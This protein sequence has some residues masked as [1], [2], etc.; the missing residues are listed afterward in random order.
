LP[1]ISADAHPKY[2]FDRYPGSLT[3]REGGSTIS[4]LRRP[5]FLLLIGIVFLAGCRASQSSATATANVNPTS[6]LNSLPPNLACGLSEL[7]Y[8]RARFQIDGTAADPVTALADDGTILQTYWSPGFSLGLATDA[9]ASWL[10]RDPSGQVVVGQGE[11][12]DIPAGAPPRLHG[13]RV[14]ATAH[15]MYILLKDPA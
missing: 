5:V 6:E 9:T 4:L 7:P 1:G 12:L 13:H 10:V 11:I 2:L 8:G 3:T 15:A 14:C